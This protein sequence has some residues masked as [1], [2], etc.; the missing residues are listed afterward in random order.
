MRVRPVAG[1]AWPAPLDAAGTVRVEYKLGVT[2]PDD[3]PADLVDA[4]A[5]LAAERYDQREAASEG[6][7][8]PAPYGVEM[9][10]A[11]YR[12]SFAGG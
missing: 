9:I 12:Q 10:L 3:V 6:A 4:V 8:T 11:E 5:M 2:S 7:R 1:Y